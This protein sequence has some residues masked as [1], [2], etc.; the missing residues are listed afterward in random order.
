MDS[1][2][3]GLIFLWISVTLLYAS[4]YFAERKLSSGFFT[5]LK[6][7]RD[8]PGDATTHEGSVTWC[9]SSHV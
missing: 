3:L 7:H 9:T 8:I 1:D 2:P 4:G 6:I 5:A